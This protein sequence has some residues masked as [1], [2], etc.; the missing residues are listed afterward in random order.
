MKEPPSFYGGIDGD[1]VYSFVY[2]VDIYYGLTG[3][4]NE[5][6]RNKLASLLLIEHAANWYNMRNFIC[7]ATWGTL[8]HVL[9][10]CFKPVDYNRLNREA[11]DQCR[12]RSSDVSE[13]T[14]AFKLALLR[15]D[16]YISEE[17]SLHRF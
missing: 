4:I 15:C 9:L 17:E 10:S 16:I 14:R 6:T 7:N 8:K 3:I 5:Q 12:Q 13:Y 1:T 2:A 11:L